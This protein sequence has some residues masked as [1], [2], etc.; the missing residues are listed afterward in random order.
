[1]L[2]WYQFLIGV[3]YNLYETAK[4]K[5]F[6]KFSSLLLSI[7]SGSNKKQFYRLLF[8]LIDLQ[9]KKHSIKCSIIK[10]GIYKMAT[11]IKVIKKLKIN[12]KKHQQIGK[13]VQSSGKKCLICHLLFAL[14]FT[15]ALKNG[16]FFY[17]N[18]SKEKVKMLF[19]AYKWEYMDR[20][21]GTLKIGR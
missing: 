5:I 18:N 8:L 21:V 1:M 16:I 4:F 13:I 3:T 9:L 19:F 17:L 7:V 15:W 14:L 12:S 11:S 6:A 2:L 20:Q 10:L